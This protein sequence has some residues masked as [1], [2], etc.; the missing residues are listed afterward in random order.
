MHVAANLVATPALWVFF[1]SVH[2]HL[3]YKAYEDNKKLLVSLDY[4]FYLRAFII[5]KAFHTDTCQLLINN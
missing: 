3:L 4:A 1:S 5:G 2:I